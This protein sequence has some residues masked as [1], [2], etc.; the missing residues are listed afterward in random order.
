MSESK[1]VVN[2]AC[3][4][5]RALLA[6]AATAVAFTGLLAAPSMASAAPRDKIVDSTI[7]V[8]DTTVTISANAKGGKKIKDPIY[9]I[10]GG[11]WA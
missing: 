9:T 5:R 11:G 8:D 3:W 2:G 10:L 1:N 4:T 7:S 6:A